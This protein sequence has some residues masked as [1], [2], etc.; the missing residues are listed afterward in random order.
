M[1]AAS[2]IEVPAVEAEV[3]AAEEG[4]TISAGAQGAFGR[5]GYYQ[6]FLIRSSIYK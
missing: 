3:P 2:K 1:T 6:S 5:S 4:G